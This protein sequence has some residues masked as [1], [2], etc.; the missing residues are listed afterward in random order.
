MSSARATKIALGFS[1][2]LL[3]EMYDVSLTDK[4]VNRDYEGEINGIGSVLNI[5]NLDRIAEKDYVKGGNGN[6]DSLYENNSQLT[7]EK[8]KMFYWAEYTIDDWISYI[9]DVHSTVVAQ[10]ASERTKNMDA[11][12]FN[13]YSDV[14]AGNRIGTDVTGTCSIDVNGNVTASTGTPFTSGMVGRGFQ[15]TGH[16]KAYRVKTYTDS[17]HVVIEND[18]DDVDSHYDGGVISASTAFTVEAV[19]SVAI[20]TSNLLNYVAKLKLKLNIAERLGK[21]AVPDQDRWLVVPPEFEDIVV[22]ANGIALHID[23]VYQELVKAGYIGMLQGFKVFKSN[24]LVGDNTNGFHCLA[25]HGNWL[26]FAEKLLSADIEEEIKGDFGTAYKDLLVYGGKVVDKRRHFAT[27][28]Y[29][30]FSI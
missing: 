5:Y 15:A 1:Q 29:F 27:E 18:E 25:G 13:F 10:K 8:K 28:G 11:Y 24:R 23:P 4:I 14:A 21:T 3:K 6:P 17:T 9:K 19:T 20:T 7:I 30:T 26:T 16:S 12:V 22:Q 2:R